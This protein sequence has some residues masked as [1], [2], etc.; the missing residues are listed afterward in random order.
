[1]GGNSME[2]NKKVL[3]LCPL[4]SAEKYLR[5]EFDSVVAQT[6]TNWDLMISDDGAN[7]ETMDIVRDF[8]EKDPRFHLTKNN[9]GR[10]G[11]HSN[12]RNLIINTPGAEAYDYFAY[13]DNDDVWKPEKLECYVKKAEEIKAAKGQDC[14]VC[15]TSNMEVI[16]ENGVLKDPDFASTYEYEIQNPLD[17]FFTH[18]V[19]GCNLFFDVIIYKAL[20]EVMKDESFP[21]SISFDNFTYQTAA[22]LNADLSFLPQVLMSY[23]RHG[24][25][26]TAGAVYKIDAKYFLKALS[27]IGTVIH[28]NA[29]IARDSIDAIDFITR[30]PLT[31][32]RRKELLEIREGLEKGGIKAMRM[33]K[34]YNINCGN[35]LRTVE[36]WLSLCLGLERK[37]MDRE[38]YPEL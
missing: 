13:M 27:M 4:W 14:P 20:K 10:H 17:S 28:N 19:F 23:R 25:N 26:T 5:Q 35:R 8:M 24:S 34:K 12:Y 22:A 7:E 15:L 33:W 16:D 18:R 6:Y 1:M 21:H 31:P 3:I 2:M 32:Q 29:F 36:N 11:G 30:L 38:K 37:Y 9:S